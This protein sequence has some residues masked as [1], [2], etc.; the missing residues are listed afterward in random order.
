MTDWIPAEGAHLS[1]DQ[2]TT[3]G[4]WIERQKQ[5]TREEMV[6]QARVKSSP[7]H[8]LFEWDDAKLAERARLNRAGYL[9][10]NVHVVRQD[11]A[12]LN[13]VVRGIVIVPGKQHVFAPA[14]TV[15]QT[16]EDQLLA[17]A[18]R[19]LSRIVAHYDGH[20]IIDDV[21]RAATAWLKRARQR[22]A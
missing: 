5:V 15:Y 14:R 13:V 16:V 4:K 19:D 22:A 1:A 20:G 9:M 8:E 21:V 2:A 17:E 10:V 3:V 6:T 18:E 7:L 12:G 11:K